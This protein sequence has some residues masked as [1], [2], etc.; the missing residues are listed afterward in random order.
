[1]IINELGGFLEFLREFIPEDWN[2]VLGF[3]H[4]R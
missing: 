1:V 3:D 2:Q 4:K